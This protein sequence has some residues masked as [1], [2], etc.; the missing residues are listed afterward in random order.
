M[1]RPLLTSH[2]DRFV[3]V[4]PFEGGSLGRELLNSG[5]RC[6]ERVVGGRAAIGAVV[7]HVEDDL[8]YRLLA[9]A[10]VEDCLLLLNHRVQ[11]WVAH[12]AIVA[13]RAGLERAR[14]IG[15]RIAT[16]RRVSPDIVFKLAVRPHAV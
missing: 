12:L 4:A 6:V 2:P 3:V 11:L 1:P 8:P 9:L 13:P 16:A 5:L 15:V 14:E 10:L 7:D